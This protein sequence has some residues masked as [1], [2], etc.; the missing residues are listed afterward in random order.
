MASLSMRESSVF[1]DSPMSGYRFLRSKIVS[2][3]KV[4]T[5][6]SLAE[7]ISREILAPEGFDSYDI[8]RAK[9]PPDADGRS[10]ENSLLVP[11]LSVVYRLLKDVQE[12]LIYRTQTYIRDDIRGFVP[13]KEDLEYPLRL[14]EHDALTV[15]PEIDAYGRLMRVPNTGKDVMDI[16]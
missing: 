13:S 12:R 10:E 5:L 1:K 14:F 15:H 8:N 4:E 3:Q 7:L 2:C 6:K 16:G 11:V 9:Q